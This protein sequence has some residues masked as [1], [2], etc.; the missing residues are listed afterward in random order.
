MAYIPEYLKVKNRKQ[1]LDLFARYHQLS[2]AEIAERT[3]MSFPTVSK[4][5]E[6]LISKNIVLETPVK[7]SSL[8]SGIKYE[9]L[10]KQQALCSAYRV[11]RKRNILYF[12]PKAYCSV[13]LNFEGQFVEYGLA[14]L[15]G[16]VEKFGTMEFNKLNDQT[17]QVRLG[18]KIGNLLKNVQ[19]P[20]LGMGVGLPLDVDPQNNIV[21]GFREKGK[22]DSCSFCELF[23]TMIQTA[24][25]E[26]MP[27]FVENDVNLACKGEASMRIWESESDKNLCYLSL[28]TGFGAGI[29]LNGKILSGDSFK[30]GEI[31][32]MLLHIPDFK[33]PLLDQ[34]KPIEDYINIAALNE[35][36]HKDLLTDTIEETLR[37]QMIE[38]ILP[39]LGTAVYNMNFLFDIKTYILSGYISSLLGKMFIQRVEEMVNIMLSKRGRSIEI[40]APKVS[41]AALTGA[42]S[43]VN[44][45]TILDEMEL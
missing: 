17:S 3:E 39:V 45:R 8:K 16:N 14:D 26:R 19:S 42:A 22:E 36:F 40:S 34:I 43:L 37:T 4:A 38:H 28:G 25:I 35:I 6:F 9:E 23:K 32:N 21:M 41:H 24:G 13:V 29:M 10:E 44:E 31:G 11:G 12:N 2:R 30:A 1:V 15:S 7:L 27:M 33:E 5:V 20:V 18:Q